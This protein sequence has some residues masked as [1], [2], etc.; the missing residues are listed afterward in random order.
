MAFYIRKLISL[1][2][3]RL[4]LSIIT[5]GVFQ[6]LPGDPASIVLGVDADP[7]QLEA[8]RAQLGLDAPPLTQYINWVKN[9]LTLNFGT[10]I[11]FNMPV[12]ELI[13]ARIPITT[14]LACIALFFTLLD[15]KSVV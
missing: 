1:L 10:S 14:S 8:M 6:I 9:A 2:V 11:R 12:S 4:L 13:L 5:F 15:R 7:L 3:T